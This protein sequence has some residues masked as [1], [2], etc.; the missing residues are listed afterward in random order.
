MNTYVSVAAIA[1]GTV[2]YYDQWEDGFEP[3]INVPTQATTQ[4]WGDGDLANGIAPGTADDL[5]HAG[6]VLILDNGVQTATRQSVIDFDGGDKVAA[7]KTIAMTRAA[8]GTGSS[9]LLAGAVEVYDTNSWGTQFRSPVGET[10]SPVSL[11]EYSG[12]L[13]M[14]SQDGTVVTVDRDNN[15][16]A[17]TTVTLNEGECA[18]INGGVLAGGMVNASQPV[19]V[20]LI[21]GDRCDVYESR[22]YVLTPVEQWGS[23]YYNPVGTPGGGWHGDLCA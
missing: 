6:A 15:G 22:W 8:W 12:L 23:S 7:T 13:I 3:V 9:T 20:Q 17:E 1:D 2:I 5:I 10:T 18:H 16:S 11:F 4:I 19:Q 14:A 21:T